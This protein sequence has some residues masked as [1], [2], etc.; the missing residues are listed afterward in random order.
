M[1]IC[2]GMQDCLM[3]PG[4]GP[5]MPTNGV[6]PGDD[7]LLPDSNRRRI[8]LTVNNPRH[9]IPAGTSCKP[10]GIRHTLGLLAMC[11]PTPTRRTAIRDFEDATV[12][13][14]TIDKVRYHDAGGHHDLKQARDPPTNFFGRT[15]GHI[16]GCDGR[17]AANAE[18]RY[19][20]PAIDVAD[21]V[22]TA[23]YRGKDL[24]ESV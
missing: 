6:I 4:D 5:W 13:G 11:S 22:A 17:Y 23:C 21:P 16:S 2:E 14:L 1:A 20:A 18:A 19:D 10:K 24:R 3:P 12:H 8:T 15:F 9:I 7:E